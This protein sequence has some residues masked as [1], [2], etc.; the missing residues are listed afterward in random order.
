MEKEDD[1]F[2]LEG[3]DKIVDSNN[4]VKELKLFTATCSM[5]RYDVSIMIK[6]GPGITED[7]YNLMKDFQH[8][9]IIPHRNFYRDRDSNQGRLAIPDAGTSFKSWV[10]SSEG[11]DLLIDGNGNMSSLFK[12]MIIDIC[13]AVEK[14]SAKGILIKKTLIGIIFTLQRK[15]LRGFFS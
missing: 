4:R 6:K 2:P 15:Q 8:N 9:T 3:K 10:G 13:D 11:K 14:S 5:D 12:S 1:E 7:T